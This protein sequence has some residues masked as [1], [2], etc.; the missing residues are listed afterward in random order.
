M[1]VRQKF[2]RHVIHSISQGVLLL[3]SYQGV[4]HTLITY[5]LCAHIR[6]S[7]T[8]KLFESFSP[9]VSAAVYLVYLSVLGVYLFETETERVNVYKV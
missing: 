1:G 5:K 9:W 8:L 7:L 3:L 4:S 2:Q 6:H